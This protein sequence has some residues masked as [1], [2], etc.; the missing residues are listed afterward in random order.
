[1]H[2]SL[3]LTLCALTVG[4]AAQSGD[5]RTRAEITDYEETS[6][7]ADVQRVIDGMRPKRSRS[8]RRGSISA[9][10]RAA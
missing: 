5:M 6:T 1:M 9:R 10:S 3:A 4:L 2:L 8:S 7:Y